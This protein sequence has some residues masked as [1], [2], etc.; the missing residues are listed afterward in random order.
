[1]PPDAPR[2]VERI[3]QGGYRPRIIFYELFYQKAFL[4]FLIS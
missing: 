3:L 1:M 2:E 4:N